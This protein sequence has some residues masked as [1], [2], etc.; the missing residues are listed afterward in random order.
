MRKRAVVAVLLTLGLAAVAVARAETIQEF[1]FTIK[2]VHPDGRYT[3]VF[4]SRSYDR[5]GGTPDVL[6]SNTI[7][8]PRGA[9]VRKRFLNGRYYCDLKKLVDNLRMDHPNTP[10]FNDLLNQTLRDKKKAPK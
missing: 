5:D 7:R 1:G 9:V 3:V 2:D 6:V 4:D 10:H 8:I